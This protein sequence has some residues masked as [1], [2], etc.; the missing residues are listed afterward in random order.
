MQAP[1]PSS[2]DPD[3][4]LG[5]MLRYGT[6]ESVDPAGYRA[7]VRV[8]EDLLTPPLRWLAARAGTLKIWSP[9]TIGEQVALLCPDGELTAGVILPGLFYDAAPAPAAGADT[10]ITA[11][12]G[13]TITITGNALAIVAPG[14]VTV[15]GDVEIDGN[16]T[17]S[18][19][20]ITD[21]DVIADGE[22]TAG[23]VRLAT[24][25]HGQVQ[26]GGGQS[27]TPV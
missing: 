23:N 3:R 5:D 10:V 8:D 2:D 19:N 17:V 24:H 13:L 22:V 11:A 18:G 20:I 26:P 7:R 14:R 9:P 25:R 16:L 21:G 1:P 27:G 6:I 12:D 4:R 15:T